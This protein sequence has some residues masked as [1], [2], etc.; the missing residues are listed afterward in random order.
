MN[1]LCCYDSAF[2]MQWDSED[3]DSILL[4]QQ[5]QVEQDHSNHVDFA[6]KDR[7]AL[8]ELADSTTCYSF[9]YDSDFMLADDTVD[10]YLEY[11]GVDDDVDDE[12][13]IE[14]PIRLISFEINDDDD[15]GHNPTTAVADKT[16]SGM[17]DYVPYKY[18]PEEEIPKILIE[19]LTH[20]ERLAM[21]KLLM[22]VPNNQDST[23]V[24]D[25]SNKKNGIT[26][27]E[28]TDSNIHHLH[29]K[30]SQFKMVEIYKDPLTGRNITKVHHIVGA[31]ETKRSR[32]LQKMDRLSSLLRVRKQRV[33]DT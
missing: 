18:S 9:G 6:L 25:S 19:P 8:L 22:L 26:A 3:E 16:W 14:P 4:Y 12:R 27:T 1:L 30:E 2:R 29:S 31:K 33:A 23:S 17:T 21:N 20:D 10:E 13:D 28:A 11:V 32:L 5:Q 7:S 15:A 24:T